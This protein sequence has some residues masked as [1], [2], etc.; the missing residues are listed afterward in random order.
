MIEIIIYYGEV[1]VLYNNK[2]FT[3]YAR[4][5]CAI[6]NEMRPQDGRR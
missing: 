4:R 2:R 6:D 5:A 1:V 3:G